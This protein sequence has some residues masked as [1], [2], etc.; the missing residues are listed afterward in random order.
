MSAFRAFA[1]APDRPDARYPYLLPRTSLPGSQTPSNTPLPAPQ[2]LLLPTRP[3]HSAPVQQTQPGALAVATSPRKTKKSSAGAAS[4]ASISS[5]PSS[6][7]AAA[8]SAPTAPK[9]TQSLA[10]SPHTAAGSPSTSKHSTTSVHSSP[11]S[12]TTTPARI[13]PRRPSASSL[14]ASAAALQA[15]RDVGLHAVNFAATPFDPAT[16]LP[17][18]H[19]AQIST[20]FTLAR[21]RYAT[22]VDERHFLTVY[23]YQINGCWIMWDY[24]SGYVHL[25][26]LWKAIGN[27]K[28]DIVKLLENSPSLESGI[29][30]VRGGFLKIQGTWLPYDVARTLASRTCYHIR[31]ALIPVF[32]AQFPDSCLKPDEPG[33]GQLQLTFTEHTR[34]RRKRASV[35]APNANEEPSSKRPMSAATGKDGKKDSGLVQPHLSSSV[36]SSPVQSSHQNMTNLQVASYSPPAEGKRVKLDFL[37]N[38]SL[39]SSPSDFL[40]AL[41]ATKSLQLLSAGVFVN[42]HNGCSNNENSNRAALSPELMSS[43]SSMSSSPCESAVTDVDGCGCFQD[44]GSE[45]ECGDYLYRWDGKQ[46]LNVVRL[47]SLPRTTPSA[48]ER[49][50]GGLLKFADVA[51][52]EMSRALGKGVMNTPALSDGSASPADVMIRSLSESEPGRGSIQNGLNMFGPHPDE[53][54]KLMMMTNGVNVSGNAA[55]AEGYQVVETDKETEVRKVMGISGLLS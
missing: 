51:E 40:D 22:S 15:E 27:S 30:R 46:E 2:Q 26:G 4:T 21:G 42:N 9:T 49:D 13:K 31:Y 50:I 5:S 10:A 6:A 1:G 23:E 29:R 48:G 45:F 35:A 33:F 55:N 36:M 20:P 8:R 38:S 41:Q 17:P 25:T 16:M 54:K 19:A 39:T 34:K 11:T 52:E 24:Y 37:E 3:I 32:G 53:R 18:E 43:S 47:S 14:A 28:A 7:P 12:T 44:D